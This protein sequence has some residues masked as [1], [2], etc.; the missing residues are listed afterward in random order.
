MQAAKA[1]AKRQAEQQSRID[2]DADQFEAATVDGVV[3]GL[4][5]R[6]ERDAV[7]KGLGDGVAVFID[8]P[9]VAQG[10]PATGGLGQREEG[11]KKLEESGG[12]GI[13]HESLGELCENAGFERIRAIIWQA[14]QTTSCGWIW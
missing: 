9:N 6:F 13:S 2:H 3:G 10:Q 11:E 4:L 8:M 1:A 12:L 14:T 7:G 5:V